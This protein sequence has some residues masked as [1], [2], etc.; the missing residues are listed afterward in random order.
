LPSFHANIRRLYTQE[1][2]S[3]TLDSLI[4][5]RKEPGPDNYGIALYAEKGIG[6]DVIRSGFVGLRSPA[7]GASAIYIHMAADSVLIDSDSYFTGN[8]VSDAGCVEPYC[9]APWDGPDQHLCPDECFGGGGAVWLN[10]CYGSTK[11][12]IA[13]RFNNNYLE[14]GHGMGGAI[15]MDWIEC[16]V[17]ITGT[18]ENN[19]ASDGGAIHI[20]SLQSSAK[21]N[22]TAT[23][24][25]NHA[26]DG[27][28]G[29]RGAA[30][31]VRD[32]T[33]KTQCGIYGVYEKNTVENGRGAMIATNNVLGR[34]TVDAIARNNLCDGRGGLISNLYEFTGADAKLTMK[35]TCV[36]T[37]NTAST[38]KTV[39][40]NFEQQ[41]IEMSEEQWRQQVGDYEVSGQDYPA[42]Q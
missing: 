14:F 4:F 15:F 31:R 22:V 6:L 30:V 7:K 38:D 23:F 33:A 32:I 9:I 24:T 28:W 3:I 39:V 35:D 13:A 26:V 34:L 12:S 42:E 17:T 27:G 21:L 29:G 36:F 41:D 5:K 1:Y 8:S 37:N 25:A 19:T 11:V 20:E 10:S 2:V 16:P 40:L 18:Y